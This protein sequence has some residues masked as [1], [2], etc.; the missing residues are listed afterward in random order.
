MARLFRK[1]DEERKSLWERIRDVALTD[2]TVLAKGGVDEGSIERL[3]EL[4]IAADFGVPA[5]LR[6]T[7]AVESLASR[8]IARSQA[9]F[10]QAVEEEIT[11]ILSAGRSDTA[12]RF[13]FEGGPTVIVVAG[14]NGVGKTTSIGKLAYRLQRSG[15][16]VLIAAGDTFRAG[17]IEQLKRWSERVGCD[18]V[19]SE[20]GR[21]PAAVA[22]D[23]LE[24]AQRLGSDVVIIDTAGR[25]HTQTGLMQ[26]LEKVQRVIARKLPGAPHEKLLVLD[27]TVGQNAMAQVRAFG[28]TID[29]TGLILT[30]MDST[31]KGGIVVA[32]K[33]EFDLPVKFIGVGEGID[34]LL[35][36]D[37]QDFAE[38]VLTS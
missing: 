23:A 1:K 13:N 38:E 25:L 3:E 35:P 24:T 32:L 4:L 21:D 27:S 2:V 37:V 6:L 17:A 22:F 12:L 36:F 11:A 20:P 28:E 33:Q 31:A 8:G 10:L 5:T 26:E 14:V 19:G 7:G 30:K 15:R 16:K 29:L 9:D 34:D 18:F